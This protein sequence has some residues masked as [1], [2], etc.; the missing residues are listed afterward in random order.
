MI[1]YLADDNNSQ[2]NVRGICAQYP[3]ERAIDFYDVEEAIVENDFSELDSQTPT[4]IS[5]VAHGYAKDG[6][7][8]IGSYDDSKNVYDVKNFAA[9]VIKQL[10]LAAKA[11]PAIKKSLTHIDLIACDLGVVDK[12]GKSFAFYF[13]KE[14]LKLQEEGFN[15]IEVRAFTNLL[16]ENPFPI[17]SMTVSCLQETFTVGVYRSKQD[18]E[19]LEYGI[20]KYNECVQKKGELEIKL[21]AI[22]SALADMK[23]EYEQLDAKITETESRKIEL[24]EK[25]VLLESELKNLDEKINAIR[26]KMQSMSESFDAIRLELNNISQRKMKM[27][28]EYA[29]AVQSISD[30]IEE[31]KRIAKREMQNLSSQDSDVKDD[32]LGGSLKVE[33]RK[34]EMVKEYSAALASKKSLEEEKISILE[35]EI[36]LNKQAAQLQNEAVFVKEKLASILE[37]QEKVS[38]EKELL[39]EQYKAVKS[40]LDQD[41]QTMQDIECKARVLCE[42]RTN[43]RNIIKDMDEGI[44]ELDI[45]YGD[46]AEVLFTNVAEIRG[47]L[48]KYAECNFTQQAVGKQKPVASLVAKFGVVQFVSSSSGVKATEAVQNDNQNRSLF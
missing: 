10:R 11:N 22:L 31:R 32:D 23:I 44:E 40:D 41:T 46:C 17:Y 15:Q 3:R 4:R 45:V 5:Y 47:E 33:F 12:H 25:S 38:Q 43:I 26:Q 37:A 8:L 35:R 28:A 39:A 36:E 42:Q 7:M 14:L 13:A 21:N 2:A 27:S 20:K 9:K 24:M 6:I 1:I 29:S 34:I 48:D 19:V 16:L 18:Y 30:L